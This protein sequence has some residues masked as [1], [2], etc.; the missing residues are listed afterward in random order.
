MIVGSAEGTDDI[1][2]TCIGRR[3]KSAQHPNQAADV[4]AALLGDAGRVVLLF[5]HV[6]LSST[7]GLWTPH[8]SW[9]PTTNRRLG[10]YKEWLELGW[11]GGMLGTSGGTLPPATVLS[12]FLIVVVPKCSNWDIAAYGSA[13]AGWAELAGVVSTGPEAKCKL[14]AA[15]TL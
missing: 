13:T 4:S 9:L 8:R 15:S 3:P 2:H 14:A 10:A 5:H 1:P 12:L 11:G 7:G 6:D